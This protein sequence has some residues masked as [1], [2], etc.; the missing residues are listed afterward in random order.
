M[1]EHLTMFGQ[2]IKAK[3]PPEILRPENTQEAAELIDLIE[4]GASLN[5]IRGIFGI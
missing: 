5:Q 1:A 2:F 4:H 3:L